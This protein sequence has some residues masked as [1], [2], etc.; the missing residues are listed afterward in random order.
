[1]RPI[2]KRERFSLAFLND[3][4]AR[5]SVSSVVGRTVK[6]TPVGR[7]F[8]GLSPFSHEK[9]PSFT[10]SD[11][12]G[13]YHCFSTHEHG[14]IFTFMVRAHKM[15]FVDAVKQLAGECGLLESLGDVKYVAKPVERKSCKDCRWVWRRYPR[16][17][18]SPIPGHPPHRV[19]GHRFFCGRVTDFMFGEPVPLAL[20][21]HERGAC[22]RLGRL[23]DP[24][25]SDEAH[26]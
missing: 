21:R 14:D 8:K 19:T 24:V 10:V 2:A 23:H 4:R 12:K 17:I 25:T 11:E 15:T 18:A 6:L 9:S 20:A 3:I 7:E 13:F 5:I 16:E 22:G 1:M 26:A